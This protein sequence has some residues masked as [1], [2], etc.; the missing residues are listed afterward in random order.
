MALDV[1]LTSQALFQPLIKFTGVE[2]VMVFKKPFI[3]SVINYK[4][5]LSVLISISGIGRLPFCWFESE[6]VA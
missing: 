3:T 1:A 2:V 5:V 4:K 6:A